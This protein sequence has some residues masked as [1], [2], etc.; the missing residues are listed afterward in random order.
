MCHPERCEMESKDPMLLACHPGLCSGIT[1][2][3]VFIED[4]E[5]Y[6]L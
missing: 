4:F 1:F 5:E 6:V 2:R 3:R